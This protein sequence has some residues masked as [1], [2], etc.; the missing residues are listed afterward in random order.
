MLVPH[1]K[2]PVRKIKSTVQKI[3]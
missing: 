2:K 3:F 1:T